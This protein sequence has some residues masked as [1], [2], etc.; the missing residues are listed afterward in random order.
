[1]ARYD[2]GPLQ[3]WSAVIGTSTQVLKS[4]GCICFHWSQPAVRQAWW[5]VTPWSPKAFIW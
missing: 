5:R 3:S 2:L 1:L 4:A